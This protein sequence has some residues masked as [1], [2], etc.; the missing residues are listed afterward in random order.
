MVVT[1]VDEIAGSVNVMR[2]TSDAQ[3]GQYSRIDGLQ[4]KGDKAVSHLPF[5]SSL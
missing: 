5:I 3:K 2:I 1:C 4:T